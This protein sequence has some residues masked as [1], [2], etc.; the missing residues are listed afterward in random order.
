MKQKVNKNNKSNFI[1][2]VVLAITFFSLIAL[3]GSWAGELLEGGEG[4]KRQPVIL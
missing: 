4:V 3:G 2:A 1:L